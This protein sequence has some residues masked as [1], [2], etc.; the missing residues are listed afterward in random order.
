M[1][2]LSE[3]ETNPDDRLIKGMCFINGTPLIAVIDTVVTHS[4]ISLDCAKRLNPE[5]SDMKGS[6]VIDTPVSGSV[7]TSFVCRNCP[8]IIFGRGFTIDLVFLPLEQVNIILRMY[9]FFIVV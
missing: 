3:S 4:F 8:I 7:T 1:F 6:M 5:I 9:I 2:A